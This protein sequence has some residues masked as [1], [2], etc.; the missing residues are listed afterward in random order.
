MRAAYLAGD[1]SVLC[2]KNPDQP[3]ACPTLSYVNVTAQQNNLLGCYDPSAYFCSTDSPQ[4]LPT[5]AN[6]GR[7]ALIQ[8]TGVSNIGT[9]WNECESVA[10]RCCACMDAHAHACWDCMESVRIVA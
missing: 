4:W 8:G 2:P 5:T 7:T 6:Y 9:C 10:L 3:C 1:F